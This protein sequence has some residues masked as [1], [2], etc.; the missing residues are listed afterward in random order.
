MA[1]YTSGI[2]VGVGIVPRAF[3][4][5]TTTG[6]SI[7]RIFMPFSDARSLTGLRAY[8]LHDPPT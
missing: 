6:D 3:Q 7:V 8:T 1:V 5:A 4:V 2:G